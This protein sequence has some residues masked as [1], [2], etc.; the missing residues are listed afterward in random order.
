MQFAATASAR[1]CCHYKSRTGIARPC[2][3]Y[4]LGVPSC[5]DARRARGLADSAK[6]VFGRTSWEAVNALLALRDLLE[7]DRDLPEMLAVEH[8]ILSIVREAPELDFDLLVQIQRVA[9]LEWFAGNFDNALTL[10]REAVETLR[11]STGDRSPDTLRAEH[12]LV[13]DLLVLKR[14]AEARHLAADLHRRGRDMSPWDPETARNLEMVNS[15]FS[16]LRFKAAR[17]AFRYRTNPE[18]RGSPW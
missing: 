13:R 3:R 14:F 12:L 5:E 15:W 10:D 1:R 2:G 7:A 18:A 16:G 9:Q 6:Q 8:Q 4:R 17:K 11:S